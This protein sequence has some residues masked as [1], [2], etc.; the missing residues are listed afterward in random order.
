MTS[1][2]TCEYCGETH[3]DVHIEDRCLWDNVDHAVCPTCALEL[4]KAWT[5][6]VTMRSDDNDKL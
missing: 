1:L 3:P 4:E 2:L 5:Q 6:Y